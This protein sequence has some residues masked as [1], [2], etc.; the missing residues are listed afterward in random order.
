MHFSLLMWVPQVRMLAIVCCL[1]FTVRAALC[2]AYTTTIGDSIV[3]SSAYFAV[4]EVGWVG[5]M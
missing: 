4:S 1:C 2:F 5:V 3:V